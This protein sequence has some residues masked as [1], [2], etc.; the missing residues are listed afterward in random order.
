VK[1]YK[2]CE[3]SMGYV[4]NCIVYA[5]KDA[6]YGQEHP[7]EQTSLRVVLEVAHD[8][9]DKAYCLY[10]DNWYTSP[11]LVDT[12]CTRKTDV[13]LTMRTSRKEFPDFVKRARLKREKR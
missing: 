2:L 11:K 1:I 9:L 10:L 5:G 13:V 12:L 7:G 3:S 6:V 4:W 8:L